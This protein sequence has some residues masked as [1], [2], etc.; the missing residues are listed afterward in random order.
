MNY[1]PSVAIDS[2]LIWRVEEACRQAWPAT[3]EHLN[4]G[5]LLR[6]SGGKTRRTNSVNPMPGSRSVDEEVLTRIEAYYRNFDQTPIFRV[7]DFADEL[8]PELDRRRYSVQGE[9]RTLFA[10]LTSTPSLS[11][12][13]VEMECWPSADWLELRDRLGSDPLLFRKMIALIQTPVCF[14]SAR[15]EGRVASIAYGVVCHGMLVLEAVATD[16]ALQGRGLAKRTVG[17]LLG[18]ARREGATE[19]CLQVL[20]GNAPAEA[21]YATLGFRR[22]L[23]RYRYRFAPVTA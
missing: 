8:S 22:E 2:H 13:D 14:A 11:G 17:A 18:W 6:R 7:T 15:V 9:T 21:L 3:S 20:A 23:Y 19:A 16:P 1:S 12:E 5:W 10:R 4:G